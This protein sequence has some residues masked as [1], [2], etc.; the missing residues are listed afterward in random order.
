MAVPR[1]VSVHELARF[2]T[3]IDARSP[4]EYAIDHLPGAIN[5]PVLNDDERRIVGTIYVQQGAFE[6]RR[7]GGAMVAANLARHLRERFHDQ[8]RGWRPLVYCWRGGMRSG[9][10]VTWLRLVG[11]DAQQ[12][13]QGYKAWR[14]HVIDTLA[15]QPATLRWR[16]LLGPTGSAKTRVLHA[17]AARGAQVL[18]L[19]GLA[20][21]KGSLLGAVPGVSQPSQK[22]FETRLMMALR[23]IDPQ[24]PLWVE[25]E[26]R[27]IGRVAL[28][29]ALIDAMRS[30]RCVE[31][32]AAT[33]ARLSY[34]LRDY[35]YLGHNPRELAITLDGLRG[36]HANETLDRWRAWAL[37]R[38]LPALY[39]ELMAL[40]YDPLYARSTAAHFLRYA[41]VERIGCD[42]LSPAGIEALADRLL[43]LEDGALP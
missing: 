5:C 36:L 10:L 3:I 39:A 17:L 37:N 34:L 31:V 22:Q 32:Q 40:H 6:A 4:A 35:A 25:G 14:R 12:L 33:A 23:D 11:W 30:A 27:K 42:D 41:Q 26:S 1:P 38:A 20:G 18:D 7:I 16:V 28:P 43:T 24:R 21:H 19:E 15:R 2:D 9:A 13:A 8:P 29:T